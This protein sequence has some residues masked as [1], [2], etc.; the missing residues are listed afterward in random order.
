MIPRTIASKQ[1]LNN[2]DSQGQGRGGPT[3]NTASAKFCHK[4]SVIKSCYLGGGLLKACH[5][6]VVTAVT[7]TSYRQTCKR[8]LAMF[9]VTFMIWVKITKPNLPRTRADCSSSRLPSGSRR[10]ERRQQWYDISR[11][12]SILYISHLCIVSAY[13]KT[14]ACTPANISLRAYHDIQNRDWLLT[15][16]ISLSL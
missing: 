14:Y 9:S 6:P 12:K 10:D 5:P 15:V 3:F 2:A 4:N 16:K 8:C 1:H 13:N 7:P 11:G